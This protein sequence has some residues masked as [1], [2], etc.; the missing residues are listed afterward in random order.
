MKFLR[1]METVLITVVWHPDYS[2][3]KSIA[4]GISDHFDRLGMTRDGVGLTIPV[5]VRSESSQGNNYFPRPIELDH[6][7]FNIIVLLSEGN[8]LRASKK[9]WKQ[10][11]LDLENDIN[12]RGEKDA[13]FNVAI[14]KSGLNLN[15][16]SQIQAL[17]AY[18]WFKNLDK[19]R[20]NKR[21]LLHLVNAIGYRIKLQIDIQKNPN[22]P[23]DQIQIKKEQLFLSHAKH[24]GLE[25][26]EAIR[27]Y[28]NSSTFDVTT[29]VDAYDLP[30]TRSF[31]GQF[32]GKIMESVFVVIQTDSY[33][34]RPYCRWEL[35][36][37]KEHNRPIV[38]LQRLERGEERAFPYA[39]NVPIK[40]F[41]NSDA[42]SIEAM[43][44]EI[45]SEVLRTM[46]WRHQAEVEA[47]AKNL[48]DYR[49]LIRPPELID[50]SFQ[51]SK[52]LWIYPDPPIGDEEKDRI[53]RIRGNVNCIPLSEIP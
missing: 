18:D 8:L 2:D 39:G 12:N 7:Q 44:L 37:A 49:V 50:F 6:A 22:I 40:I 15:T 29:F 14:S 23:A 5:R 25:I 11:F 10:Y 20:W 52:T 43:L 32:E 46:V 27:N 21:V 19:D 24:D 28:L 13:V 31:R 48:N 47:R 16:F 3:G 17:R 1:T 36:K 26:V 30:V 41:K 34:T 45:M 51:N 33:S 53:D 38:I 35:L 42:S 4:E 9:E